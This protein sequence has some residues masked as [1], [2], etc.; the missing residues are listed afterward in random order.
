MAA[1]MEGVVDRAVGTGPKTETEQEEQGG[2]E[3]K[4]DSALSRLTGSRRRRFAMFWSPLAS[5]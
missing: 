4:R 2:L 1:F 5:G 3:R